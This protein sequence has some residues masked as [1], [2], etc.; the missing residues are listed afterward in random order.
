[1][2]QKLS[3][4]TP[5]YHSFAKDQLLTHTDLNEVINFFED[6]DRLSRI[7][8]NGVGIICGF[9]PEY[10]TNNNILFISQGTG[11]TTDGDLINFL[12]ENNDENSLLNPAQSSDEEQKISLTKYRNFS[13]N[14][15]QYPPFIGSS[16]LIELLPATSA[17]P[18][19]IDATLFDGRTLVLYIDCYS[20][21]PGACTSISCD[22]QGVEE[23][24]VLRVL[25]VNDDDL[26]FIT[27]NDTVF[28]THNVIEDYLSLN[29]VAMP[30]V[31]LDQFNTETVSS[32][33]DIYEDASTDTSIVASLTN[34]L[35]A[36][37]SRVDFDASTITA[38]LNA[39]FNNAFPNV[40]FQ[41]YYDLLKDVIDSHSEIRDLFIA[42]FPEC[43][44]DITAFP[45]HL[46]LG[47]QSEIGKTWDLE[48]NI[49]RHGYY[50]SPMIT[51]QYDA[52]QHLRSILKRVEL[53]T[54]GF[55]A[56][57]AASNPIK[58]SPSKQHSDF[59]ERAIPF[60]SDHEL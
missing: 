53:M 14:N 56:S 24:R 13:D 22:S 60:Y 43:C 42:I 7:C 54:S 18:S 59:G 37:A 41:Y 48:D 19:N 45:K 10:D 40:Y 28:N 29:E 3:T 4:I 6:Q 55:I 36:I 23:I 30:R 16:Q 17:A 20:K 57:P 38:N 31:I 21:E 8:L 2:S 44:A 52:W 11:V 47:K 25:L 27:E 34:N 51:Q 9:K 32:L 39:I 5:T 15:A 33:S 46:I 35:Q 26:P 49:Y 50:P 1:M 58:I 12:F